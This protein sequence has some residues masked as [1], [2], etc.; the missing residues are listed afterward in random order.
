MDGFSTAQTGFDTAQ[1]GFDTAQT[2]TQPTATQA[3]T[4]WLLV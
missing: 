3:A 4:V 1:T 2:P